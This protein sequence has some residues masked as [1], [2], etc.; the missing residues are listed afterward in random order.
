MNAD[1]EALK[2][3]RPRELSALLGV[4][5]MTIHRWHLRD[6]F[7]VK[8]R[9]GRAVGFRASD[10]DRWLSQRAASRGGAKSED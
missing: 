4:S 7:P 10:V 1:F 5:L 8:I 9:M 3:I 6:D 2:I